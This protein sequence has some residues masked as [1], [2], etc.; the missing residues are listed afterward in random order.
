MTKKLSVAMG[1]FL[2]VAA[3]G[4]SSE[5]TSLSENNESSNSITNGDITLRYGGDLAKNIELKNSAVDFI[6]FDQSGQKLSAATNKTTYTPNLSGAIAAVGSN[7][8]NINNGETYYIAEGTT[9]TGGF[10]FNS[11]GKIIVLGELGGSNWINVPNGGKVEV[12]NNGKI[13][14]SANFHLNSGGTLDNYGFA[15]YSTGSVD[16]TIN[17]FNNLNFSNSVSLNGGSTVNNRCRMVFNAQNNYLNSNLNNEGYLTFSKGFNVNGSGVLNLKPQSYTEVTGGSVSV[18]GKVSNTGSTFARMD[19]SNMSFA[20]LN[21]SPAFTGF[22][23]M[24]FVNTSYS[25]L[26]SNNKINNQVTLNSN[27]FIP[28]AEC[29]PQKGIAPCADTELQ[30]TLVAN[31]V[32][33]SVTST[34]LSATGVT[35][36]NGFAYVSYHTNDATAGNNTKGAIRIINVTDYN[37]PSLVSEALFNNIEFNNVD[38]ANNKL[39]AVGGDK[40]GAKLVT[41]PLYNNIFNTQDLSS[42]L[43]YKLPS[44]TAKNSYFYNNYLYASTGT[45]GGG[46]FKLNPNDGYSV[47]E[48]FNFAGDRAKY[49]AHNNTY[50]VFLATQAN[51][52]TLRIANNDGSNAKVY[53]YNTL[54]QTVTD[55]KN[56]IVLDDEY[57]YL[58]LSDKGV[59]KIRLS[60]GQLMSTFVPRNF[61]VNNQNVFSQTGLTNAVAV[62]NCYLYLANGTDGV[63]VLNKNSFKV[64]GYYKLNGSA[65]YIYINNNLAFVASGKDG[66]NILKIN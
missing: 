35:M 65:N 15:T 51:G 16:G 29:T 28:A 57:V 7:W 63:I 36:N 49:V 40:N 23:D 38:V 1:L 42:F 48:Q 55:G 53:T 13:S 30:F 62:N 6:K 60:D 12:G 50:Q 56:A 8:Y 25:V 52:A 39:Y 64:V 43:N 22:I 27:A 45:T 26:Q 31:V 3:T 61:K 46:F 4:C 24:N 20:N 37:S 5:D 18:D 9:F 33:P 32:S 14:S 34:T 66:L 21:A 47:A 41:A 10:N 58:A 17:N 11:A 2:L 59:A 54:T 44:S 19:F